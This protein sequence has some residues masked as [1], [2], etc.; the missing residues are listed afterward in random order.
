MDTREIFKKIQKPNIEINLT[1][2]ESKFI[3]SV[4]KQMQLPTF[5]F[6]PKQMKVIWDIYLKYTGNY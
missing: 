4:D 5:M 2:W 1:E 3:K 6:S